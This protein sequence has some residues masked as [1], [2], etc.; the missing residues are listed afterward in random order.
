MQQDEVLICWSEHPVAAGD[1]TINDM[2]NYPL[3][4]VSLGGEEDGAISGFILERGLARQSEMYDRQ[5]LDHALLQADIQIRGQMTIPHF[6]AIPSLL[7]NS[8]LTAIVPRPL[9]K[10]FSGRYPLAIRELPYPVGLQRV[11]IVW[12]SH[13]DLDPAHSWLRAQLCETA[14]HIQGT[15]E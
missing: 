12:H 14:R 10:A 7:E 4:V 2:A 15:P 1:F 6:L 13:N 3:A 5:A 8:E 9:A 11:D